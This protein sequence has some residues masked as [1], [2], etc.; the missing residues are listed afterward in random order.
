MPEYPGYT[1]TWI[2]VELSDKA[3][4]GT[5]LKR[6]AKFKELLHCQDPVFADSGLL[7]LKGVVETFDLSGNHLHGE[8]FP[9]Q[10]FSF[11]ADNHTIV[12]LQGQTLE[13]FDPNTTDVA[14]K[15]AAYPQDVMLQLNW[16]LMMRSQPLPIA[17]LI[18]GHIRAAD[19]LGRFA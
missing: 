2:Q 9:D 5:T 11:D 10:P 19:A 12:D 13:V 17:T 15:L 16:F 18:E 1:P 4:A 14:A 8:G 7:R 3:F 6:T